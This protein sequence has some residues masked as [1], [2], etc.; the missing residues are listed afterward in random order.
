MICLLK[1]V[2]NVQSKASGPGLDHRLDLP[3]VKLEPQ[4]VFLWL[5]YNASVSL[6]V[7]ILARSLPLY[8]ET[9]G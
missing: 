5:E 8:K 7:Y 3:G 6:S 9:D 1:C 4:T 2:M